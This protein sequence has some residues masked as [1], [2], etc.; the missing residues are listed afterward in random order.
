MVLLFYKKNKFDLIN[1]DTRILEVW[2][3]QSN[4]VVIAANLRIFDTGKEVCV[5]TTHL[6]ARNGPLLAKLR[7]EQGKVVYF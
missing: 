6:K 3:V 7:N 2:R 4:Q 5:C 1:Y